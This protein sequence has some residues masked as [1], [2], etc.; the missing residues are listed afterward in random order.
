[1]LSLLNITTTLLETCIADERYLLRLSFPFF[2]PYIAILSCR[3][4]CSI[5]ECGQY[6]SLSLQPLEH[7]YPLPMCL[8]FLTFTLGEVL[9]GA[10]HFP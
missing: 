10:C 9:Y 1:M 5:G 7:V 2:G 4:P 8:R 6:G 3:R